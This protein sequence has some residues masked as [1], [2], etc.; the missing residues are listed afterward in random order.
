[1]PGTEHSG[2]EKRKDDRRDKDRDETGKK[3][4]LTVY[5]ASTDMD[6]PEVQRIKVGLLVENDI[7]SEQPRAA[8]LVGAQ[9]EMEVYER[10][11][12]AQAPIDGG[13][14]YFEFPPL[15]PTTA[16]DTTWTVTIEGDIPDDDTAIAITAATPAR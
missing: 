11:I 2:E 7:L 1:M 9:C 12:L 3:N 6:E 4:T 5:A 15:V 14:K 13:R 8:N 16:D 10:T